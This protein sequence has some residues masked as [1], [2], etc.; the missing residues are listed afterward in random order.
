MLLQSQRFA[1][2]HIYCAPS[3]DRQYSFKM[4]RVNK[5]TFPAKGQIT[6]YGISKPLPNST[7]SFHVFT[8]GNLFPEFLNLQSQKKHWLRDQWVRMSED[9]VSRNFIAKV[10]NDE[11]LVFPRTNV[12]YSY[13]DENALVFA[14]EVNTYLSR[15]FDVSS[16]QYLNVYSN[17]YFQ[18]EHFRALPQKVGVDYKCAM[19]GNNLEKTHLQN[20][21]AAMKA[22]GGDVFVYV[23]GCYTDKV[24]LNIP[25]H[26]CVEM[27]YDQSVLARYQFDIQGLR[28]FDSV[29]DNKMKYLLYRQ[30]AAET[31][32]YQDDTEVYI[33]QKNTGF[34]QG[35]LLYRHQDYVM[36]NVTDKDYSLYTMFV[37]NTAQTLNQRVGGGLVDKVITLYVRRS[38][39]QRGLVYNAMKLHELYKL[40]PEVQ[41]DMISNMNYTVDF[42]RAEQLENSA[43]FQCASAQ[44]ISKITPQMAIDAIGYNGITHYYANTPVKTNSQM[45]IDVPELYQRESLAFEYAPDGR[46]LRMFASNGPLY[47]CSAGDVGF[48]DFISGELPVHYGEL[49]PHE[50]MIPT[51]GLECRVLSAYFNEAVRVSAWVDITDNSSKCQRVGSSYSVHEDEGKRVKLVCLSHPRVYDVQIP[52]TLGNLQ[53]TLT[54]PEDRGNGVANH[55]LDVPYENIEIYLN[56]GYRLTQGLDYFMK[57]PVVSIC[58]KRYLDYSKTMQDIHIRMSGFTLDE[59]KINQ[60]E[61]R[62][63]VNNGALT[64]NNHYDIRDDKVLS[65]F[66]DGRLRERSAVRYSEDDKTLRITHP[67]NGQSYVLKEPFIPIKHLTGVDTYPLYCKNIETNR[68]ISDLYDLVH[69]EPLIDQFNAIPTKHHVFSPLVSTIITDI[70]SGAIPTSLYITPYDDTAILQ[71]ID[72]NYKSLFLLDPVR[73]DLPEK[74]VEIFP[75][76]GNATVELDLLQYRFVQNVI[77][78]V[79]TGEIDKIHI[80][81]RITLVT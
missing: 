53:F 6:L 76:L 10:Y 55:P 39:L 74:L 16:Y 34:N 54:Q 43:Y 77:R 26:S 78:V 27:V 3:Q 31:L 7:S 71:L 61:L 9:M 11:G 57:F 40:P 24:T 32:H 22:K 67:Q 21:V 18:S 12:Y 69:P 25:D 73:A 15:Q 38:G 63:F 46:Y 59:S 4:S 70:K 45:T 79:T 42:Y 28:T 51:T 58:S 17:T 37:N 8:L 66:V 33:A 23:D 81:S 50:A 41:C 52:L 20:W 64:R 19:V 30:E 5:K 2:E 1:L 35:L 75:H 65:V 36:R 62:G 56:D 29:K 80:A 48:V 14:V 68:R 60:L 49:Y 47:T 72:Q 13:I 44:G